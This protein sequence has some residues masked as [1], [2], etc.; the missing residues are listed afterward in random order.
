[1]TKNGKNTKVIKVT[2]GVK[3]GGLG[4]TNHNRRLIA[5]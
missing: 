3:A 5:R 2:T 1:M 4:P